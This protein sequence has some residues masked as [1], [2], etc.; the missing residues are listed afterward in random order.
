MKMAVKG[1]HIIAELYG[2]KKELISYEGDV[3][4]IVESV[5]DEAGLVRIG[6][7]YKQ[8][9]PYGVTGIVLI[10]ESH[11][12]IHTWPEHGLVNLDI[13]TCGEGSKAERAFQLFLEHLKPR[14]YK[15]QVLERGVDEEAYREAAVPGPC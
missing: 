13:F 12:S 6:S 5:V 4:E 15:H 9:H 8:F 14:Y 2:V 7:V 3:R 1:K 11:V 10:A